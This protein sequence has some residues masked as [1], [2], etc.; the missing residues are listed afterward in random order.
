MIDVQTSK[1]GEKKGG[2]GCGQEVLN[3]IWHRF[4]WYREPASVVDRHQFSVH[5]FIVLWHNNCNVLHMRD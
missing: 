3:E 1:R 2:K 4:K 5:S